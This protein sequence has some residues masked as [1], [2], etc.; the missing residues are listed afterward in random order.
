M[1][2]TRLDITDFRNLNAVKLEPLSVGFNLLYGLNGSGKTSLLEAIYYLS[3]GRSFRSSFAKRVIRRDAEKF[4]IF[5]QVTGDGAQV[6]PIGIERYQQ[7]ELKIRIANRDA[8]SAAELAGLTPVQLINSNCYNLLDAGPVFRRKYL[9]WG[10]FYFNPEFLRVWRDYGQVLKQRNAILRQQGSRQ[11]LEVWTQ[12][13]VKAALQFDRCRREYVQQLLPVLEQIS[14][15]LLT[16]PNLKIHYQP[17][18][19]D[20][21]DYAAVLAA[22]YLKDSQFGYTQ[23]GPHRADLR[24]TINKIAA[25]DIL[26]RGQQK[27]FV[28]AMILAQSALLKS[29]TNKASIYLV[30]DL[31]AE[32]DVVSRSKLINLLAKQETQVFVTAVERE[33]LGDTLTRLPVK[34]FHVEHGNITEE[35]IGVF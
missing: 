2:I 14:T 25:K 8:P 9:D 28:C 15:E 32:L 24:I 10:S 22:S 16:I 17:G 21:Q 20:D 11:E 12:E 19:D 1:P 27:L 18:W 4:L 5:S 23:N 31:P 6:T 30:D 13:L 29:S 35:E 34:M 26:S 7:G 33:A 3:L